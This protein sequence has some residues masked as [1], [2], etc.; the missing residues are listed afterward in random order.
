VITK[1]K[2]LECVYDICNYCGYNG[3]AWA[4][5][6][7]GDILTF[8]G[9]WHGDCHT[10]ECPTD[11]MPGGSS[12]IYDTDD[13]KEYTFVVAGKRV[14]FASSVFFG[15]R[16]DISAL[17]KRFKSDEIPKPKDFKGLRILAPSELDELLE[18][19]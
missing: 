18:E 1:H 12:P 3:G 17:L 19:S 2:H 8:G 7:E 16:G 11:F 6:W 9:K 13:R 5:L 4:D 10:D 15:V 14:I